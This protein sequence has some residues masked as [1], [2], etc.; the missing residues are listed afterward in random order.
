MRLKN[1]LW[2]NQLCME[3]LA[4]IKTLKSQL[5]AQRDV[6]QHLKRENKMLQPH[7]Y[8]QLKTALRRVR[9]AWEVGRVTTKQVRD[10]LGAP[11]NVSARAVLAGVKL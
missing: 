6:I 10:L 3:R 9:K 1:S 7:E 8:I 4:T 5:R 2:A 11:D